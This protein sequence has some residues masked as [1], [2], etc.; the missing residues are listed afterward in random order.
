MLR[1]FGLML[2]KV[3]ECYNE[4][5]KNNFL[6]QTKDSAHVAANRFTPMSNTS[7]PDPEMLKNLLEPLL[8]DF[9]YWF[10]RSHKL[11]SSNRLDF[12]AEADQQKM[13]DRVE[14]ALKEVGVAIALFRVTSHQVGV[15]MATMRPWHQ[16]LME[17]Q[18]IGMRYYR[19]QAI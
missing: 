12:L 8:E 16:L 7:S 10:D 6:K 17:C 9:I 11:L 19:N 4:H 13:L 18:A 2:R 15:D 1:G 5:Y 3:T 14:H